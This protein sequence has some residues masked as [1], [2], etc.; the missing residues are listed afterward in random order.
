MWSVALNEKKDGFSS[1]DYYKAQQKLPAK[2]SFLNHSTTASLK[3]NTK[4][5]WE[6]LYQIP[7]TYLTYKVLLRYRLQQNNLHYIYLQ[8][9]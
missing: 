8:L 2:C 1:I 5:T 3:D 4:I 6:Q 9:G 7:A